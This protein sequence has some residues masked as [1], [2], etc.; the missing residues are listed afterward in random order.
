MRPTTAPGRGGV[1]VE[2]LA[3]DAALG[4]VDLA[5][6]VQ[7]ETSQHAQRRGVLVRG[8]YGTQGVGHGPGRA[9]PCT[10]ACERPLPFCGG[11][12]PLSAVTSARLP[13]VTFPPDHL[14]TG[15]RHPRPQQLAQ[16]P[17][18]TTRDHQQGNGWSGGTRL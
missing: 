2:S 9:G 13:Q 16:P 17:A 6:Q 18:P 7:V 1:W 10:H 8:A 3:P 15:A 12:F 5:G 4:L 11:S 14:R